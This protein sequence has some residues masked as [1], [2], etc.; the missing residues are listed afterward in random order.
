MLYLYERQANVQRYVAES[1]LLQR[2]KHKFYKLK[3]YIAST[4]I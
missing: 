4:D 1:F 3:A 2:E